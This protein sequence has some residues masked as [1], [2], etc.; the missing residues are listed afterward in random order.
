[1]PCYYITQYQGLPQR[2]VL[3][4]LIQCNSVNK[5]LLMELLQK[6]I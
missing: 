5:Y 1:M 4:A 6:V 2:S 3:V